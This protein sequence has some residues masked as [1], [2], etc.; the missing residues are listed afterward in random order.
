VRSCGW[1]RPQSTSPPSTEPQPRKRRRVLSAAAK[2][3][4]A[5]A[6]LQEESARPPPAP[7]YPA[8]DAAAAEDWRLHCAVS[9]SSA[10]GIFTL[11]FFALSISHTVFYFFT[12]LGSFAL[13]GLALSAFALFRAGPGTGWLPLVLQPGRTVSRFSVGTN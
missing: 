9:R 4:Q 1:A 13:G 3:Q 5:L 6:W 8:P 11:G 7:P 10:L 2:T 12:A